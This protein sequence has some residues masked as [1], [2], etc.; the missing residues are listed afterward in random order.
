[1]R[2]PRVSELT[3]AVL[4]AGLMGH[5][6]AAVFAAAG[7]PVRLYDPS[8][9]SLEK[10]R[11]V[12]A[13]KPGAG[14]VMFTADLDEAITAADL[15]LEVVPEVMQLK[16]ELLRTVSRAAPAAV[17]ATNTSA[18][19]IT[20]LA[21]SVHDAT[22]FVGAHFFNPADLIPLVEVTPGE[23]TDPETAR[24]MG[25]VLTAAG[26]R[27]VHLRKDIPGFIA[28][29]LQHALWREAF[30]LVDAGVCEPETIDMVVLQSFGPR[31][32]T[33]GPMENAD[34]IGLDLLAGVQDYLLPHLARE[35][36]ASPLLA[37][38]VAENKVGRK[39]GSGLM[40]WTPD[41][42]HAVTSRLQSHLIAKSTTTKG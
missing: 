38:L 15:V 16:A 4:G 28:N 40:D 5:A 30:A 12:L 8:P 19:R 25:E 27:P 21:E 22:R 2:E 31:L 26:K 41:R 29:R 42:D 34:Y 39:T 10:A 17:I 1:M 14:G 20:E 9:T 18:F 33:V 7:A 36:S 23:G 3:I 35:T 6:I 13:T 11:E 37:R 24:W 32:G